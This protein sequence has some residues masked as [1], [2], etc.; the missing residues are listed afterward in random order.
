MAFVTFWLAMDARKA[1]S[2]I[3][4]DGHGTVFSIAYPKEKPQASTATWEGEYEEMKLYVVGIPN[5]TTETEVRSEF[6]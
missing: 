4:S 5:F 6:L 1:L 3:V 2:T